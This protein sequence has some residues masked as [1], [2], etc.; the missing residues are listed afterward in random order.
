[1]GRRGAAGAGVAVDRRVGAL[2]S[3]GGRVG[4]QGAGA[5]E[6]AGVDG[7]GVGARRL[8]EQ[9]VAGGVG[10]LRARDTITQGVGAGEG[11]RDARD[12]GAAVVLDAVAIEVVPD[13]VADGDRQ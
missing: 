1:Q 4:G 10:R 9:V 6:V 2:E 3:G 8:G 12:A 11:Q 5:G 13:I 7:H